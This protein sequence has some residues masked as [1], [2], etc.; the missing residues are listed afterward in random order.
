MEAYIASQNVKLA[1][2][3]A[4][5][6]T[7]PF[8]FDAVVSFDDYSVISASEVAAHF[9]LPG[10]PPHDISLV[11]HKYLLRQEC[12]KAGI[13]IPKSRIIPT[14]QF[15]QGDLKEELDTEWTFPIVLK[16]VAGAGSHFVRKIEDYDELYQ[17]VD[18]YQREALCT[19][20]IAYWSVGHSAIVGE[21]GA[22]E[23][24]APSNLDA[25]FMIEELM[26]G[27]EVDIDLVVDHGVIKFLGIADNFPAQG[28]AGLFMES[29]GAQPSVLPQQKQDDLINMTR[30]LVS[31]FGTALHGVFHFEAMCLTNGKTAPIE[32]NL[33]LGGS[34][35]LTFV[36]AV[37]GVNLGLQA[38][39]L[40]C[41]IEVEQLNTIPR[42]QCVSTN[43][44][45]AESGYVRKVGFHPENTINNEYF[46][47]GMHRCWVDQ[48]LKT[49]PLGYQYCGWMV[50][51]GTCFD[52]AKANIEYASSGFY[53]DIEPYPLDD[54]NGLIPGTDKHYLVGTDRENWSLI[55]QK[56]HNIGSFKTR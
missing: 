8:K 20:E 31:H 45:A 26:V 49:P 22:E 46:M 42:R 21:E 19:G 15:L 44:L 24:P 51:S 25:P 47:G 38:V 32:L 28:P 18:Q 11:K 27:S 43:I 48:P 6:T 55:I 52:T 53:C 34:E 7:N 37:Y 50:V 36:I 23:A 35:V 4:D 54:S 10:I 12:Q 14:R 9:K 30:Q 3:G 41:G 13:Y 40:A 17:Y 29:G 1:A 2:E 16:P 39:K 5:V 56:G 33:R